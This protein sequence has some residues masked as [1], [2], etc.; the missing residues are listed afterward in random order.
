MLDIETAPNLGWTWEKYETNVIEF[1]EERYML[2]FTVKWLDGKSF[3][4]GLPD[5]AGYSK[6]PKSDKELVLKLK[7]FVDEADVIVAH[8]GD[9][10]DIK[11]MNARFIV[12]GLMPPSP[13]KTV[14]TKKETKKKFGFNSNSLNE[15]C[16]VFGIGN[17]ASTGGFKLWKDC[18]AG[19]AEAWKKMKKY[20]KVDVM[21]LEQLYLKL[22]PWMKSHPNTAIHV[23]KLACQVCASTNTQKRGTSFSKY[24]K[25]QRIQCQDC[26]SWS[27][28]PVEK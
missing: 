4:Y 22:R 11:I 18:M 13:Y 15:L 7:E 26:G 10:F 12:N 21:L 8:N 25:Y 9:S 19:K 3:T 16:T 27:Q 20:N 2:C 6:N 14:D 23:G 17:K 28:G 5:F 1:V 24:T